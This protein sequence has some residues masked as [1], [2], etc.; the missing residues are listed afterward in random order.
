M[1]CMMRDLAGIIHIPASDEEYAGI[2][3]RR[4]KWMCLLIA[5]SAA[6]LGIS[7]GNEFWH[8]A[9]V[10]S[11]IDGVYSGLGAGFLLVGIIQI[12]ACRKR[13]AD[14]RRLH[15]DRIESYD[16]RTIDITKKA[17]VTAFVI[18]SFVLFAAMLTVGYFNRTVF[19]CCWAAFVLYMVVFSAVV[20]YYKRKM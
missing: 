9:D 14:P 17:A 3:R 6:V 19:W 7:I 18:F 5:V 1:R 15:R 10:D 8:F 4:V 13:L 11:F 12:R 20:F 2:I 16:E